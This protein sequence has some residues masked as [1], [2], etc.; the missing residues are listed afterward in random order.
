MRRS[1]MSEIATA[2]SDKNPEYDA[3]L[4]MS[5][6]LS[7]ILENERAGSVLDS[8]TGHPAIAAAATELQAHRFDRFAWDFIRPFEN[9]AEAMISQNIAEDERL[10]FLILRQD[11]VGSHLQAL[12]ERF[13][14]SACCADKERRV[15]FALI[16]FFKTGQPIEFD[17]SEEHSYSLPKILLRD[18]DSIVGYFDSLYDLYYGKYD[19]YVKTMQDFALLAGTT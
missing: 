8:L 9:L 15:M 7:V 10:H 14:G 5:G 16:R 17:Y 4:D 13:E 12:F 18:H 6:F 3:E 2:L 11:F 1:K 19:L